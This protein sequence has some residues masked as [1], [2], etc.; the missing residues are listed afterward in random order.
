MKTMLYRAAAVLAMVAALAIALPAAG[1]AQEMP[2]APEPV[3]DL[4]DDE[5]EQFAEIYLEVTQI[6]QEME[7]ELATVQDPEE[8]QAIQLEAQE[9]MAEVLEA[10]EMDE[11]RY[12]RIALTVNQDEELRQRL[13]EVL[14]EIRTE[15][16]GL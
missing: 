4:D 8:A 5:L 2:P 6:G 16:V 9:Q 3:T 13:I 14:E 15:G 10:H 1:S 12:R 11:E 7:M